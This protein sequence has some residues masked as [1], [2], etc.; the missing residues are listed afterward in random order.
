MKIF[1]VGYLLI[2]FMNL[3]NNVPK[4]KHIDT[5]Y[6]MIQCIQYDS[7]IYKHKYIRSAKNDRAPCPDDNRQNNIYET[8]KYGM[9]GR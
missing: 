6:Y 4:L 5:I 8:H 9:K 1:R 7:Q 3:G 2:D